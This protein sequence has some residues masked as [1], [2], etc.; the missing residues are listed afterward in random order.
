M[1][2]FESVTARVQHLLYWTCIACQIVSNLV[3]Q[4]VS[5]K[6]NAILGRHRPGGSTREIDENLTWKIMLMLGTMKLENHKRDY[7]SALETVKAALKFSN[8]T[9]DSLAQRLG[10]LIML[11]GIMTRIAQSLIYWMLIASEVALTLPCYHNSVGDEDEGSMSAK[12]PRNELDASSKRKPQRGTEC[13]IGNSVIR[14]FTLMVA[15]RKLEGYKRHYSEVLKLITVALG[16]DRQTVR[17]IHDAELDGDKSTDDNMLDPRL[18]SIIVPVLKCL[19]MWIVHIGVCIGERLPTGFI[20]VIQGPVD[21]TQHVAGLDS[22]ASENLISRRS[23]VAAGLSL[24][25]YEGPL[26]EPI[27]NVIRPVG[28]VTFKWCVSNFDH[29]YTTTFAVLEDDH[30]KG[31]NILLSKGEIDKHHFYIRNRGVLFCSERIEQPLFLQKV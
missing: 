15:G 31:F 11:L 13:D 3:S 18:H 7:T 12:P 20:M 27:G 14:K 6:V 28:R 17:S 9:K 24:E 2:V 16:V 29:W 19:T 22:G 1:K 4:S 25:P 10:R 23:A 21:T 26:L 30:C 5:D 8:D